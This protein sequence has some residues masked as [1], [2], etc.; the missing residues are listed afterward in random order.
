MSIRRLF[1]TVRYYRLGQIFYRLIGR[2]KALRKHQTI[3]NLCARSPLEVRAGLPMIA[4]PVAD[5][6]RLIVDGNA[7][8][9]RLL[10]REYSSEGVLDW[11]AIEKQIPTRLGRFHLHYHEYFLPKSREDVLPASASL[12]W[13]CIAEWI[14]AFSRSSGAVSVDAWHPYV[15]SRRIPVW[16]KLFSLCPPPGDLARLILTSLT[17]QA[18]FLRRNLEFD[19]GGNHLMQNLRGLAVAGAFFYGSEAEEWL[20]T[21]VRRLEQQCREQ[22]LEHGEHFERSPMYHVDVLLAMADIR[23]ALA[24]ARK[25]YPTFLDQYIEKMATFLGKILHPDGQIPLF[26][27]STLDLT[28]QPRQ[29]FTRLQMGFPSLCPPQPQS[30]A[31]GDYWIYREQENFLI[32]D[33][34]PVGPDYLPAH[35]HADLLTV[36]ASWAGTRLFVDGGVYDYEDSPE[37]AYCRSTA[38]HNTAEINGQNQCDV[39][40]RFR[41]GRRGWPG[42]LQTG[43]TGRFHWARCTHNAYRHLNVPSVGRWIVCTEGGPWCIVDS[44]KGSPSVTMASRL[45]LAPG[46]IPSHETPNRLTLERGSVRLLVE[47]ILGCGPIKCDI[48]NYYPEFQKAVQIPVLY[49]ETTNRGSCQLAWLVSGEPFG[50]FVFKPLSREGA[51][52]GNSV[53][54]S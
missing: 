2:A 36:E 6:P 32:F 51:L 3:R 15:I 41:M 19:L 28:P 11:L 43:L 38:A 13:D 50:P 18:R 54:K 30:Y 14:K 42:K 17:A 46:W 9:L 5:G 39:W 34:G 27:D 35:A 52:A 53:S 29:V 33:G 31:V 47:N 37:R 40:S 49:Y 22:I 16:V 8:V 12:I 45:R 44:C 21:V 26:G 4:D 48:G 1:S 10:N 7:L 20:A 23:D 25:T 24:A